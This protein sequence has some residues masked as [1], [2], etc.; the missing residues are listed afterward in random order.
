MPNQ[1][2]SLVQPENPPNYPKPNERLPPPSQNPN[3]DEPNKENKCVPNTPYPWYILYLSCQVLRKPH[4]H[5]LIH[6]NKTPNKEL[7]RLSHA[8]SALT[9]EKNSWPPQPY[10]PYKPHKSHFHSPNFTTPQTLSPHSHHPPSQ[11]TPDPPKRKPQLENPK[12]KNSKLETP[13]NKLP[14]P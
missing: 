1:L 14:L 2:L 12:R 9:T 7:P 5:Q 4:I 3:K 8:H 6:Q 11:K 10:K 13:T